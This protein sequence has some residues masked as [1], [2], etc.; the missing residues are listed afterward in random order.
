MLADDR[1][2]A[3]GQLAHEVVGA[4]EPG[5]AHDGVHRRFG[6]GERDV[7]A[8]AVGEEERVLEHEADRAAHVAEARFAHVG[9][10]DADA[11]RRRCRRSGG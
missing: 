4:G 9:A 2:V 5:R 11:A 8:H 1:V 6:I 10:V 3:V 7:G